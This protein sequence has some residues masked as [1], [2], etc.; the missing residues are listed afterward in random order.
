ERKA[1]RA[2]LSAQAMRVFLESR[3][4][5]EDLAGE[6]VVAEGVPY[7]LVANL[8]I[9]GPRPPA[10]ILDDVYTVVEAHVA[11]RP[12]P[13]SAARR[14]DAVPRLMRVAG[15]RGVTRWLVPV[16]DE[17][18]A[19]TDIARV[20]LWKDG[21]AVAEPPEFSTRFRESSLKRRRPRRPYESWGAIYTAPSGQ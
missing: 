9:A 16:L 4:L 19:S 6:P 3:N 1:A 20:R 5:C 11:G 10:E 15:E 21:R 2:A 13:D 17:P 8:E 14:L 12:L 7:R 18:P